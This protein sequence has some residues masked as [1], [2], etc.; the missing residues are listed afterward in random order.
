[1]SRGHCVV[2]VTAA[3]A[4]GLLLGAGPAL[5]QA[6]TPPDYRIGV[7]DVLAISVWDNKDLD[8]VVFVRPDGRISLPLLGEV[9]AGGLTVAELARKL[10]EEYQ[11]TVKNA[12]VTVSVREIR[13]RPIFF[14]GGVARPGPIQ[15]TQDLTLLQAIS[16]AGG[17][18][19]TADLE[20]AFVLRA[21]Q[22]IP[23]D[24]QRLIQ[25]AD[26]SQN[27]RL[28]P[29]D[30]I[31]V[32]VADLVYV[33]GE[34][35]APGAVK[36]T[37]DLTVVKAIVQTGGFTPLAAAK[38]VTLLRSDGGKRENLRINVQEIMSDPDSAPDVPL[39]PND[40]IIVPQ[41]LF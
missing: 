17:L 41:R 25:K 3:L 23:V 35:K 20:S 16:L 8:Q 27:L 19:P 15:L 6:P 18:L 5:A 30:T 11:K 10:S 1:M 37:R 34:V 9:R 38:R 21:N 28:Q 26:V 24:F 2:I 22:R 12:Q 31:V 4:L 36:Y 29:G 14:V 39:K 33:Q 40:I 13:S 7:D 32:P